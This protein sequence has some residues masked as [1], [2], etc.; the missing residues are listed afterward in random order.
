ML[1][2]ADFLTKIYFHHFRFHYSTTKNDWLESSFLLFFAFLISA[3]GHLFRWWFVLFMH[4][5]TKLL[6]KEGK[7]RGYSE[8][9]LS[10]SISVLVVKS[11]LSSSKVFLWIFSIIQICPTQGRQ[12]LRDL[13][14]S[15]YAL[16]LCAG[17]ILCDQSLS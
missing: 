17:F 3:E 7:L 1:I 4:N 16:I 13:L 12:L 5:L 6:N 11:C 14:S 8:S 15:F 10:G 2:S 9:R